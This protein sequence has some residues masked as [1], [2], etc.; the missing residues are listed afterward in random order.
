MY[1]PCVSYYFII[2]Y[3]V[4]LL[5]LNFIQF[6]FRID[7]MIVMVNIL[8]NI[9]M[10]IHIVAFVFS[11]GYFIANSYIFMLDKGSLLCIRDYIFINAQLKFWL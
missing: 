9:R 4:D 2:I 3:M 1:Q 7:T 11:L 6:A 8:F 5:L 10:F